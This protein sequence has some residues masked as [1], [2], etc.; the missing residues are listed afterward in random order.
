MK[1]KVE[2]G[3]FT[4]VPPNFAIAFWASTDMGILHGSPGLFFD[5]QRDLWKS[6][7]TK[8]GA[9]RGKITRV[10]SC[11]PFKVEDRRGILMFDRIHHSERAKKETVSELLGEVSR[12]LIRAKINRLSL[13]LPLYWGAD[14]LEAIVWK[15]PFSDDTG[16]LI[17]T[18]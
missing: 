3:N 10:E 5:H 14:E 7:V 18:P 11:L 12:M 1:V 4:R 2:R 8:V 16:V 15:T 13:T 17:R 6:L 9:D